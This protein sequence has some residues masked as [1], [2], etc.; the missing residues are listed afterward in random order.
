MLECQKQ[1]EV[2]EEK[3]KVMMSIDY[4]LQL[5]SKVIYNVFTICD[6]EL[7]PVG[8]GLYPIASFI[9]HSCNPNAVVGF[10][11]NFMSI[12]PL[13]DDIHPGTEITV[14][15]DLSLLRRAHTH[16][17]QLSIDFVC[18]HCPNGCRETRVRRL[19]G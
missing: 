2:D 14:R 18:G 9:N 13:I 12:R 15:K 5:M 19:S 7:V 1:I 3:K 6:E 11:H 10:H 16:N 17:L 8:L 4:L